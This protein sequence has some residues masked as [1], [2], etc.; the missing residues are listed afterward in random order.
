MALVKTGRIQK[1]SVTI[2]V[3]AQES[4]KR[5]EIAAR[6]DTPLGKIIE[7]AYREVGLGPAATGRL[8]CESTGEDVSSYSRLDLG[9][10]HEARYCRE[11]VWL[12]AFPKHVDP[13]D[14]DGGS[15]KRNRA[16]SRSQ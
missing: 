13:S 11:L 6:Y 7:D 16:A 5:Y 4:G 2:T 3:V 1:G 9:Q 14:A 8:I 15:R 10:Y 12:F